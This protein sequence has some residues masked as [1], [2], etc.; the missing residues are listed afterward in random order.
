MTTPPRREMRRSDWPY[1]IR[2]TGRST[3]PARILV[4]EDHADSR[5]AMCALLEAA[6]FEVLS[7]RDGREA[8]EIARA[9]KPDLVLMDVMMPKLDGLQ[10]IRLLRSGRGTRTTPIIAVTAMDGAEPR[11]RQAGADDCVIKPL[12]MRTLERKLDEWLDD[13]PAPG[14]RRRARVRAG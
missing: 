12:D 1:R 11:V 5:D 2:Q 6:G 3:E 9:E 14:R 13:P 4:A 10:A 8:V 7:A